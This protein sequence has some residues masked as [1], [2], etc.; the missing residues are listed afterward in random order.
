MSSLCEAQSRTE[1][2]LLQVFDLASTTVEAAVKSVF[3][4]LEELD[5]QGFSAARYI[6]SKVSFVLVGDHKKVYNTLQV[7]SLIYCLLLGT[8]VLFLVMASRDIGVMRALC[9]WVP[10]QSRSTPQASFLKLSRQS[11]DVL[12]HV[13]TCAC[14][15]FACV[16]KTTNFTFLSASQ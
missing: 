3:A 12:Q 13:G 15:L 4:R 10:R 16:L 7:P 11:C 6:A 1:P 8:L 5:G 2:L 9:P 14:H